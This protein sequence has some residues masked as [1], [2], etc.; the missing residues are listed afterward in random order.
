MYARSVY[1]HPVYI[2]PVRTCFSSTSRLDS[3]CN[4]SQINKSHCHLAFDFPFLFSAGSDPTLQHNDHLP[5]G[6]TILYIITGHFTVH[7]QEKW[8]IL[9][10]VSFKRSQNLTNRNENHIP[11]AGGHRGCLRMRNIV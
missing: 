6:R 2:H 1:I 5:K 3:F 11:G 4:L 10:E 7:Q 8:K 9:E